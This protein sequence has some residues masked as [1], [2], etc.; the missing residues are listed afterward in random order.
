V[1]PKDLEVK[2]RLV[3]KF[4]R[5]TRYSTVSDILNALIDKS[6]SD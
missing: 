3:Y 1:A 5:L 4:Y 6:E 2:Q